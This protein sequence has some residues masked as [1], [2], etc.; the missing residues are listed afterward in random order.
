MIIRIFLAAL[1]LIPYC[2]PICDWETHWTENRCKMQFQKSE[3]ITL[4]QNT[5]LKH[6]QLPYRGFQFPLPGTEILQQ[7]PLQAKQ[8]P[9]K[10]WNRLYM[11]SGIMFHILT[12][13][14]S[15]KLYVLDDQEKSNPKQPKNQT[16]TPC[17]CVPL[18]CNC[19]WRG[20]NN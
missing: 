3:D 1:L 15:H 7:L 5:G 16:P 4:L 13:Y 6:I 11:D 8:I 17:S 2:A 18:F 14:P 9:T 19:K 12:E 20:E 10:F